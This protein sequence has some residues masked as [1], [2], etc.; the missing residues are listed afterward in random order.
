MGQNQPGEYKDTLQVQDRVDKQATLSIIVCNI[1]T[2]GENEDQEW[3][4]SMRCAP[5]LAWWRQVASQR[6]PKRFI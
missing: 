6:L 5:L 3:I 2:I 1:Q 4:V